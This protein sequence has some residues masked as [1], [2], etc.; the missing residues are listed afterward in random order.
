M[1]EYYANSKLRNMCNENK[2]HLFMTM[3]FIQSIMQLY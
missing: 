2:K 3:S 1:T